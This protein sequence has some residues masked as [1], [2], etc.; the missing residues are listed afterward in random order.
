MNRRR[1]LI[2]GGIFVFL[3]LLV[4]LQGQHRRSFDWKTFSDA[5]HSH[6]QRIIA[7]I[8]LIYLTYLL[9]ALR[10]RVFLEPICKTKT[11]RLIGPTFIGFAGLALLGRPGELIRPY[12]IARKDQVPVAS[13]IGVW[14]VERIFDIGGFTVLM[15]ID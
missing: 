12:L 2:T 11:S 14:T 9:R 5:S 13:Q 10:W 1:L 15:T 6:P 8:A 7:A 4:Y 3:G